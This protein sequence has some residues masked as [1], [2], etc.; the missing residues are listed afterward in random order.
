MP[1]MTPQDP[2]QIILKLRGEID[3]LRR[4]HDPA[5]YSSMVYWREHCYAARARADHLDTRVH[6]LEHENERLRGVV[7]SIR[8]I[9]ESV[10]IDAKRERGG[11]S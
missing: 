11:A 10:S 9:Y 3:E 1:E 2:Y 5:S 7:R 6:A 4:N 8:E